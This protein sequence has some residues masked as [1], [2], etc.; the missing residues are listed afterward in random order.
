MRS[1]GIFPLSFFVLNRDSTDIHLRSSV[2]DVVVRGPFVIVEPCFTFTRPLIGEYRG[3]NY[4]IDVSITSRAWC[5]IVHGCPNF[6]HLRF[7]AFRLRNDGSNVLMDHSSCVKAIVS[8]V[9]FV[10]VEGEHV[11][12]VDDGPQSS[13]PVPGEG[14]IVMFVSV[15]VHVRYAINRMVSFRIVLIR[16]FHTSCSFKDRACKD[17]PN[18]DAI[19]NVIQLPG[20]FIS[21]R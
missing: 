3:D 17:R 1:R 8:Y 20:V 6:V 11:T 5:V 10:K 21:N 16:R 18:E 4:T 13:S 19:G 15:R 9:Y 7:I 12:F 2:S 14:G